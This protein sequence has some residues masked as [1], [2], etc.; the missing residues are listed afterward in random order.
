MLPAHL[1]DGGD[2]EGTRSTW[3]LC[4]RSDKVW[5]GNGILEGEVATV[6]YFAEQKSNDPKF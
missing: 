3:G 2:S 1:G 6:R 5:V 4:G